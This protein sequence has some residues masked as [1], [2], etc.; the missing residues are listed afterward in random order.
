MRLGAAGGITGFGASGLY[1]G[2]RDG[3]RAEVLFFPRTSQITRASQEKAWR[4][5]DYREEVI[6]WQRGEG[7]QLLRSS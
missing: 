6:M 3:E 1:L 2:T 4:A 7:W 5:R